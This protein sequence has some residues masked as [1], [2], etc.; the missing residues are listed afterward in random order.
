MSVLDI[1]FIVSSNKTLVKSETT[2]NNTIAWSFWVCF[3]IFSV[4]F[5]VFFICIEIHLKVSIIVPKALQDDKLKS[6]YLIL[7]VQLVSHNLPGEHLME[8][9][10]EWILSGSL[11][12]TFRNNRSFN[13]L[14][15]ILSV[16]SRSSDVNRL[17]FIR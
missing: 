2:L 13:N 1:V 4:N 17:L 15:S 6:Q 3:L 11:G 14:L 9:I 5:F 7:L 10:F 16:W 12:L 8:N